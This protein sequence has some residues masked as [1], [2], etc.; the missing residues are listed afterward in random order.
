MDTLAILSRISYSIISFTPIIYVQLTSTILILNAFFVFALS[1]TNAITPSNSSAL[2]SIASSRVS[3]SGLRYACGGEESVCSDRNGAG[4][5]VIAPKL[6]LAPDLAKLA[7]LVKA[8]V[9]CLLRVT[10]IILVLCWSTV[11]GGIG[12]TKRCSGLMMLVYVKRLD[13]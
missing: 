4:T 7:R 5:A 9:V 1:N 6:N 2:S 8:A 3:R 10:S 12:V 11:G 13:E